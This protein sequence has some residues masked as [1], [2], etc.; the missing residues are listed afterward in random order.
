MVV[1]VGGER[2]PTHS[3][4]WLIKCLDSASRF[5]PQ[6][7]RV[8]G[9]APQKDRVE[10]VAP[11]NDVEGVTLRTGNERS[12]EHRLAGSRYHTGHRADHR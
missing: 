4:E 7:D 6:K 11:Q 1:T 12:E 3:L 9:V 2:S 5:A 10:G 8:E